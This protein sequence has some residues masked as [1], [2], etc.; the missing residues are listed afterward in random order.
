[1]PRL[2]SPIRKVV[3]IFVKQTSEGKT[4]F[5]REQYNIVSLNYGD[6]TDIQTFI[7]PICGRPLSPLETKEVYDEVRQYDS[8]PYPLSRIGY[9]TPGQ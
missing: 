8:P 3:A 4:V 1:M 2:S 6:G 7:E 9:G 5:I